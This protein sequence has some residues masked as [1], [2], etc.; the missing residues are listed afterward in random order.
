M[1]SETLR[2]T[3]RGVAVVAALLAVADGFRWGNRWYVSTMFG[4]A[5]SGN[6]LAAERLAGAHGALVAC[7]CWL[8]L[9]IV[10]AVVGWQ[11]RV[12]RA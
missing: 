9:A 12:V 7:L 6:D 4:G 10:A 3:A 1:R 5:R 8:S 2:R 11:L